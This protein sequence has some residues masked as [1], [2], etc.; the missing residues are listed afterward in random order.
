MMAMTDHVA[1]P[2]PVTRARGWQPAGLDRPL[3]IAHV[4][5][6]LDTGGLERLVLGLV[7]EGRR[8]GHS[9]GVV[10]LE[11]PG[12]LA[13]LVESHGVPV[14]CLNKSPGLHY[15]AYARLRDVFA[16]LRP[17]VVHAHQNA[18]LFYAGPAARRAGVP[19]V[20]YTEHG[21]H[22]AGA[23]RRTRLK[24][25]VAAA[26]A[27]RCF[28]VSRDIADELISYGVVPESKVC[29]LPN[30]IDTD[31]FGP[32]T[33]SEQLR[34]DLGIPR[35]APV[36][37]TVGRLTEIKR[38]DRLIRAFAELTNTHT[39]AQLVVVG[40]GPLR[41][42]LQGMAG[43]LGLTAA[44]HFTGNQL[45]PERFLRL[46]DVFVLT[47]RSEGMPVSVLEAWAAGVP[48]VASRVGG[49]PEMI[50]DGR[51]GLLYDQDDQPALVRL[52]SRVLSDRPFARCLAGAGKDH[53]E[54]RYTLRHMFREYERHYRELLGAARAAAGRPASF[55]WAFGRV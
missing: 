30:G 49:L 32:M 13:P 53:V 31:V 54:S 22:Y 17:D 25:R 48:V 34:Q 52:L 41:N 21:K 5:L 38:Q 3:R 14:W 19:L 50:Q 12:T 36:V 40:D 45:N 29:V 55:P 26:F 6:S 23:T 35:D 51:T 42:E 46:M 44:V 33:G 27:R 18:A 37:G 8:A 7:R 15:S 4:V 20:V 2:A 28:S 10:C 39:S 11:R 9:T 24:A 1:R 47:S 43:E 16:E